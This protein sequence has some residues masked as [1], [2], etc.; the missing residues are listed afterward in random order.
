MGS[1]RLRRRRK[2]DEKK[3]S[4]EIERDGTGDE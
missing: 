1:K 3:R 4:H 2:G